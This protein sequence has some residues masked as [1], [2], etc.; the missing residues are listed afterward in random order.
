MSESI[1]AAADAQ[2]VTP[3]IVL[4]RHR[5]AFAQVLPPTINLDRWLR[6]AESAINAS[7]G[8]LDIFRR[9]RGASALKALMKCAQ[10]GHEPGSGLFHLVPK[11]QAIEG[12]EDYKGIL[13]RILRSALYAKVVVA[14]VYANDEYAFDVNVDERPRH[15]QAAGDRGEPVRAYAYAV[16]RD[17]STS[18]IA[19][20]T[21]AMIAGAKAKGHKTDASTSPWQNPR[22]PMHQKVAVRELE[23]FV[24]TSAVDLR[25]TG[26][27]TDLIIEEP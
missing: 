27:V 17:G 4:D 5:D 12:W 21:P 19:E 13:Q 25:V 6:L 24:S 11:G 18:T 10:L 14:P 26:D 16:H 20:A 9:D 3:R 1:S 7:A 2:K 15:K 8:L 22:A 23:R